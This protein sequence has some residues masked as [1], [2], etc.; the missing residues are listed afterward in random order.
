[1]GRLVNVTTTWISPW[2]GSPVTIEEL[3]CEV[4]LATVSRIY[5]FAT[6]GLPEPQIL[7]EPDS[8]VIN[9]TKINYNYM[10]YYPRELNDE[11]KNC[12]SSCLSSL[13]REYGVYT[14]S[15][16]LQRP[17]GERTGEMLR[18]FKAFERLL[19][20]IHARRC[21]DEK[22]VLALHGLQPCQFL[23]SLKNELERVN[24]NYMICLPLNDETGAGVFR[25]I[26]SCQ[27]IRL[28]DEMRSDRPGVAEELFH[29]EL[30]YGPYTWVANDYQWDHRC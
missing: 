30:N 1:L 18:R 7:I 6:M 23:S 16:Y 26:E 24:I 27:A 21:W 4:A 3:I 8:V 9:S 19:R 12:F 10:I 5:L 28:M 22:M 11:M 17:S 29:L 15:D 14:A 13:K 25:A 20:L 2:N